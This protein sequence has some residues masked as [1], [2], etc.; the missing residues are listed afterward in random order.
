[1]NDR[2]AGTFYEL[3]RLS[4]E[5]LKERVPDTAPSAELIPYE[6]VVRWHCAD[7]EDLG[8]GGTEGALLPV[9][10]LVLL[11]VDVED[12]LFCVALSDSSGLTT[13]PDPIVELRALLRNIPDSS[14]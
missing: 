14:V 7:T 4:V 10:H 5:V 6:G 12:W 11:D 3:D 9:H 13:L 2:S 1:M 8:I